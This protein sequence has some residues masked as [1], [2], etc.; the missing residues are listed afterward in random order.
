VPPAEDQP[1]PE[2]EP[3]SWW[4]FVSLF[5]G[6]AGAFALLVVH[7]LLEATNADAWGL[8]WMAVPAAL[9]AASGAALFVA[10]GMSV[11]E[12][13]AAVRSGLLGYSPSSQPPSR[14]SRDA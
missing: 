3:S 4:P 1:A 14:A 6:V 5:L 12:R 8:A 2:R 9:F 10:S 7:L 11:R 13:L